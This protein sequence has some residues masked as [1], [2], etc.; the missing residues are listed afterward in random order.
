MPSVQ[1]SEEFEVNASPSKCWEF[2]SDFSNVGNCIPGCE[3]IETIDSNNVILKVKLKVGYL[4]KTFD[5][6][7]KVIEKTEGVLLKFI[8]EGQD[9][10]IVGNLELTQFAEKTRIRY[11]LEIKPISVTGKTAVTMLGKDL[12][13]RQ[14][15]DF[16]ACVRDQLESSN[17]IR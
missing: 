10:E 8:G 14:A 15:S 4:S 17:K 13:K 5:L 11:N 7:A 16:V 9:A 12:V 2:F 1:A 3:S 6:K